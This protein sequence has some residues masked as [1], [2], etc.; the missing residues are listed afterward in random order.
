MKEGIVMKYFRVLIAI[1]LICIFCS[2]C[3]ETGYTTYRGTY[4]ES[5]SADHVIILDRGDKAEY[6]FLKDKSDGADLFNGLDTGDKIELK[7]VLVT[8]VDG[9]F[10][11]DAFQCR[12]L[13]GTSTK[14]LDQEHIDN[15]NLLA[16]SIKTR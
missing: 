12:K 8:E 11:A 2:G 5:I 13:N 4:A 10:W 14:A 6:V 9:V 3:E 1:F 16:E 15:I 7:T